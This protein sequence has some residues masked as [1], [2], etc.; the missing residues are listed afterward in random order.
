MKDKVREA[1]MLPEY[2]VASL[3]HD[4]GFFQWFAR[5]WVFDNITLAVITANTIWIAIDT[6]HNHSDSIFTAAPVFQ[7]VE[8]L[9]VLYFFLEVLGRFLAFKSKRDCV[10]DA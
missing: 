5:S 9:F 2:N 10:T 3:Y 8:N 6:D 1:V 7:V 4:E